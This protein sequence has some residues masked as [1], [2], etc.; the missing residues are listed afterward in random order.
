MQVKNIKYKH[1]HRMDWL[2]LPARWSILAPRESRI[3]QAAWDD[4]RSRE[5][6]ERKVKDNHFRL[7]H[8]HLA[9]WKEVS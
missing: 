1:D 8:P 5:D 4:V 6:E 7:E 9:E 3:D 2:A